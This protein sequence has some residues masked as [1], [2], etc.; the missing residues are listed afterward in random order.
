MKQLSDPLVTKLAY[1]LGLS[2][3]G[4]HARNAVR[5]MLHQPLLFTRRDIRIDETFLPDSCRPRLTYNE[6]AVWQIM[7]HPD[8]ED[9]IRDKNGPIDLNRTGTGVEEKS[10]TIE[11]EDRVPYTASV[12]MLG[13]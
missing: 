9:S 5:Q 6:L 10:E 11:S 2:L 4:L 7:L 8:Y 12:T 1:G 13:E 3:E